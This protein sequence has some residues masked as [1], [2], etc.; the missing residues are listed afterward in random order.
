MPGA[1]GGE[2]DALGVRAETVGVAERGAA[3]DAVVGVAVRRRA[4]A[5]Q[6]EVKPVGCVVV[7]GHAVERD[8]ALDAEALGL[9]L[10]T[11]GYARDLNSANRDAADAVRDVKRRDALGGG[12]TRETE[13]R[14]F[15]GERG[16]SD[17]AL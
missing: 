14:S 3:A 16:V 7:A 5:I 17:A 2:G 1:A 10:R 13:H 8:V 11:D 12:D 9:F 15:T 4:G 6:G